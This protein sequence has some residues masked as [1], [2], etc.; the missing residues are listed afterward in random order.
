MASRKSKQRQEGIIT[1]HGEH[2]Y[3]GG[4]LRRPTPQSWRGRNPLEKKAQLVMASKPTREASWDRAG[5]IKAHLFISRGDY[6]IRSSD[7]ILGHQR[8]RENK[9]KHRENLRSKEHK[10][11]R[12][13]QDHWDIMAWFH[14]I[15]SFLLVRLPWQWVTKL[16]L[17]GLNV[18]NSISMYSLWLG[19]CVIL[20]YLMILIL[21]SLSMFDLMDLNCDWK[22]HF[23][24]RLE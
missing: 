11:W 23:E 7:S 12:K 1:H 22:I 16:F 20:I 13:T 24:S 8:K 2:I 3:S 5:Y 17:L 6:H 18:V 21:F 19:C 15:S 10:D 14:S 4:E 9:G